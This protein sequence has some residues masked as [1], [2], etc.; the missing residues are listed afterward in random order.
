MRQAGG[1]EATRPGGIE[2]CASLPGDAAAA[3]QARAK[4]AP[5]CG[6]A[7]AHHDPVPQVC[8]D[9]HAHACGRPRVH[10]HDAAHTCVRPRVCARVHV[11]ECVRTHSHTTCGRARVAFASGAHQ[12]AWVSRPAPTLR[13]ARPL[14]QRAHITRAARTHECGGEWG[15]QG[16]RD[17]LSAAH[18]AG[19]SHDM[20]GAAVCCRAHTGMRRHGCPPRKRARLHLCVCGRARGHGCVRAHTYA[21]THSRLRHAQM[22]VSVRSCNPLTLTAASPRRP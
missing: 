21:H 9:T 22:C 19:T 3:S 14:R 8:A 16:V 11:C 2:L 15:T 5:L 1:I 6:A 18:A 12:V 17:G 13:D 4:A 20:F 7:S 10:T